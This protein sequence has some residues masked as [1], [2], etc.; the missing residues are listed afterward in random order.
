[1]ILPFL[2]CIHLACLSFLSVADA[3]LPPLPD[4][5]PP[6]PPPSFQQ[7]DQLIIMRTF[8]H[9]QKD[10]QW[11]LLENVT[12][13]GVISM[14]MRK[15]KRRKK[16]RKMGIQL[17]KQCNRNSLV[18]LH[19]ILLMHGPSL[20]H[21]FFVPSHCSILF[22]FCR[23]SPDWFPENYWPK[24]KNEFPRISQFARYFLSILPSL[25]LLS[26]FG[27]QWAIF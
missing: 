6:M 24:H 19:K 2:L 4:A 25:L 17:L 1:M 7:K 12:Q 27:L 18:I 3:A 26:V 15:R 11:P 5:A 8:L 23:E 20:F 16:K 13:C 14:L 21:H 22:V 9:Q 10:M